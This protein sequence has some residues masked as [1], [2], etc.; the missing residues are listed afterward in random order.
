MRRGA[1]SIVTGVAG[2]CALGLAWG[3]AAASPALAARGSGSMVLSPSHGNAQTVFTATFHL[4]G[5]NGPGACVGAQVD[6]A[7]DNQPVGSAPMDG[8]CSASAQMQVPLGATPGGH[9]VRGTVSGGT[10]ASA[11]AT[12]TV[13]GGPSPTSTTPT[14]T[15]SSTKSAPPSWANST[16][17]YIPWTAPAFRSQAIPTSTGP[18]DTSGP[19]APAADKGFLMI[20]AYS[21]G[22]HPKN[23][24][25]TLISEPASGALPIT[26]VGPAGM[27]PPLLGDGRHPY[28]Y[29]EL[30]ETIDPNVSPK[31]RLGAAAGE[32]FS[33]LHVESFGGPGSGYGYLSYALKDALV[34][35]VQDVNADGSPFVVATPTA[36]PSTPVPAS[37][38]A[39]KGGK[40]AAPAPSTPAGPKAK[41]EKVVLGYTSLTWEYQ[42]PSGA[43]APIHRGAGTIQPP[44]PAPPLSY[45]NLVF[46][47]G[48]LVAATVALMFAYHSRRR[49]LARRARRQKASHAS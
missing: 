32:P 40:P 41:F 23:T 45:S 26:S 18:C 20:P 43:Q 33:C 9:K 13:D 48:G 19:H 42:E 46:A 34:I 10:A 16:T 6:F 21:A 4:S 37:S 24:G 22:D 39:A 3:V 14:S 17:P 29:L 1:R 5:N 49:D 47:F 35:S 11:N 27:V 25:S 30:L 2:A 8:S 44:A 15:T 7:F 36:A 38:P 12:F 28:Q 31:L